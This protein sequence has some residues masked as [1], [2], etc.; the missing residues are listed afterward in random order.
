MTSKPSRII[1]LMAVGLLALYLLPLLIF[2]AN[3][4]AIDIRLDQRLL[5]PS[6]L[7]WLGTDHLGRDTFTML[8]GGCFSSLSVALLAVSIGALI[9]LPLGLIASEK[10]SLTSR[11]ILAFNDFI[12]AFP[13]LVTAILL[14]SIFGSGLFTA[15]LAIGIFNIPVFARTVYGAARPLWTKDFIKAARLNG[16]SRAKIAVTHILPLV[17]S[18]TIAQISMQIG[19][20]ILAESGLSYVGLGIVPPMPSWGRMVSEAQTL[21]ALS[22]RL[23]L[24]PGLAIGLAVSLFI[25]I[26]DRLVDL[27]D[28]KRR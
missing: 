24:L 3:K 22:P 21:I 15:G 28:P 4:S 26:G 18:V 19:L 27:A 6:T 23:A 13:A 12:F 20:G 11:S 1:L 17:G 14:H 2:L 5:T 25:V 8:M 9:G 10:T 16:R 7:H